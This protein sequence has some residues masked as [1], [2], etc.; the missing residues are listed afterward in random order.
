M[1]QYIDFLIELRKEELNEVSLELYPD[2]TPKLKEYIDLIDNIQY[3]D[4][5]IHTF[6]PQITVI[7]YAYLN[8]WTQTVDKVYKVEDERNNVTSKAMLLEI[9]DQTLMVAKQKYNTFEE[10]FGSIC[11]ET[12]D[13]IHAELNAE[14]KE[15]VETLNKMKKQVQKFDRKIHELPFAQE[16]MVKTLRKTYSLLDCT[17]THISLR[18]AAFVRRE[19]ILML[20][21]DFKIFY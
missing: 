20:D 19:F 15:Y 5:I 2:I 18:C 16:H 7:L 4:G 8:F 17:H 13:K 1:V 11:N 12:H 9:L 3:R 21:S 6:Y 10:D 14:Y